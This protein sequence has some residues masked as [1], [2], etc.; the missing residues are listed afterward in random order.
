MF[1]EE[2]MISMNYI[3]MTGPGGPEVLQLREGARPEPGRGELVIKVAAAGVN[4]PDIVQRKGMYPPPPGASPILGLEV[5]GE[6][7]ALGKG[8]RLW[9]KGDHVCALANGGGY[10]GYVAVPETQCLPVPKGLDMTEAAALPETCFTVWS[11]VFDRAGLKAGESFLVHGGTSGIGTTAIQMAKAFGARVFTTAGSPEKCRVCETLGA[12]I[13][14]NY[15]TEDYVTVL[16]N[17]TG[18]VGVDV[19]L[20]MVG[21]GIRRPQYGPG[22]KGRKDRQY[23]LS[24][25]FESAD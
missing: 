2:G 13:A 20:D 12:E 3:E 24:A 16:K 19:V 23:C 8:C 22:G 4:R 9:E 21:G 15:R 6:V 7:A 1:R 11:N 5:A 10:A 25:R 18:G 14:V 17:A